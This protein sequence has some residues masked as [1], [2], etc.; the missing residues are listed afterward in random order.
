MHCSALPVFLCFCGR[1][2]LRIASY[3]KCLM[4]IDL[5]SGATGPQGLRALAWQVLPSWVTKEAANQQ[6]DLHSLRFS[7]SLPDPFRPS[8]RSNASPFLTLPTKSVA[9]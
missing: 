6:H 2:A 9:S 7:A 4:F 8:E 3:P 5:C 1:L